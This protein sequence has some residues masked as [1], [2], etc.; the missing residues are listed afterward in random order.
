MEKI[1]NYIKQQRLLKASSKKIE[2]KKN[3]IEENQRHYITHTIK[4]DIRT[5]QLIWY[6]H[7]QRISDEQILKQVLDL[8]TDKKTQT[9]KIA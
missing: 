2:V 4:D 5:K 6:E 3:I 9:K 1:I 7:V 8:E